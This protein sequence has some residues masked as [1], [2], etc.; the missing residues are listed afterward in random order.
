MRPFIASV[1]RG[2]WLWA[3]LL[4]VAGL[5]LFPSSG[6]DDVHI[7]YWAAHAL[8]STG[9]ILSYSGVPLEQSSSLLHVLIL[10]ALTKLTGASLPTLGTLLSI[11]FG[12][13]AVI[14]TWRLARRLRPDAAPWAAA[15]AAT[16]APLVYWSFGALETS[17][18]AFLLTATCRALLDTL[19]EPPALRLAW[20]ALYGA[21]YVMARPEGWFVVTAA[22][23]ATAVLVFPAR[24]PLRRIALLWI[25]LCAVF[26]ALVI[27][28]LHNFGQPLPQPVY[29]KVSGHWSDALA[30]GVHYLVR[31]GKQCPGL[32]VLMFA[33]ALGALPALRD[34]ALRRVLAPLIG[35]FAAQFA[36]LMASGGDWMEGTRFFVPVVPVLAVLSALA[37]ARL[38]GNTRVAIGAAAVLAGL[39]LLPWS[40]ARW[41]TGITVTQ[42]A[43]FARYAREQGIDQARFS[44]FERDNRVHLR[45]ALFTPRVEAIVD[46]HLAAGKPVIAM[47]AQ[48][49]MV[50]FHL[51]YSRLGRVRFLDMAGL[52]SRDFADCAVV[53]RGIPVRMAGGIGMDYEFY[54]AHREQMRSDCGIPYPD[55]IFDLDEDDFPTARMLEA[56]GYRV[57]SKQELTLCPAGV[58]C[59][60]S[61]KPRMFVAER[62]DAGAVQ[63]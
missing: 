1:L 21:L 42:H 8:A 41:S 52:T 39:A 61:I 11:L 6:R 60:V 14:E 54:L 17:L 4:V 2:P 33:A 5:L 28:R 18:V 35:V 59:A 53:K 15:I 47:S 40:A 13:L 63:P 51:L 10:A 36:F 50:P 49:G 46:E 25:V 48:G 31:G 58:A 19:R 34:A 26:G 43:A 23:L 29:A 57:R 20:P 32:F 12:A 27:F 44:F 3:G 30:D 37:L 38:E 45:D 7:T 9:A 62:I 16:S 22:L 56:A 55:V 24:A